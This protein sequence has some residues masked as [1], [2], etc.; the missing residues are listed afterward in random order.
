MSIY[1]RE[2]HLI[3]RYFSTK[4]VS[5]TRN[6]PD[7]VFKAVVRTARVLDVIQDI[8]GE[9]TVHSWFRTEQEDK[10]ESK[11]E[12]EAW[13]KDRGLESTEGASWNTFYMM[14]PHKSGEAVT[15]S[16]ESVPSEKV[17]LFIEAHLSFDKATLFEN[18]GFIQLTVNSKQRKIIRRLNHD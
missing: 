13:C 6:I 10:I 15:F 8:F 11:A 3:S 2:D 16:V 17:L 9:V 7:D 1:R 4:D 18:L 5:V 12:F 14:C